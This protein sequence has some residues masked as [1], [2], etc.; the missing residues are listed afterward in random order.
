VWLSENPDLTTREILD[1]GIDLFVQIRIDPERLPA[2]LESLLPAVA[3]LGSFDE[4]TLLVATGFAP[5]EF[6]ALFHDLTD[7][8]W[9]VRTTRAYFFTAGRAPPYAVPW[10]VS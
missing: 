6:G 5:E 3:L 7:Q 2:A 8:E 9:V 10:R 1:S 4:P